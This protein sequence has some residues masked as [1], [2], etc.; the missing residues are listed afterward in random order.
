MKRPACLA[1]DVDGTLYD[2]T[3]IVAD[4]FQE[5][6]RRYKEYSPDEIDVPSK[7]SIVA[8]LGQPVDLIFKTLFPTL[9]AE[10]L[11]RMNDLCT[12]TL[13]EFII[14]GGGSLIGGVHATLE[15]LFSEGYM[16]LIASNGRLEYIEAILSATGISRFVSLPIITIDGII[17]SKGEIIK[18]Y[19]DNISNDNL[20]IMI[21]DRRSDRIAAEENNIPFVGCNFGHG[22]EE[23]LAGA[24]WIAGAFEEIY[25]IIKKIEAEYI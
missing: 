12:D 14:D 1:F 6:I 17:T 3:E 5:G 7:E 15:R 16:I 20:L 21:G 18:Y 4:A 23:E 24:R 11:L 10:G 19:R 9:D 22:G 25:D 2:C 13:I 8:V